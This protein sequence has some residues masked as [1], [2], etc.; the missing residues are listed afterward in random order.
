VTI[1]KAFAADMAPLEV[2]PQD[3]SRVFLNV[4]NNACYAVNEKSKKLNGSGYAPTLRVATAD[5]GEQVEVR[6]R[7]NGLGIPPEVREQIFNPFFTTKPTGQGT[8]LG[9]SISHDIVVQ[10]HGGQLEVQTEAGEF[11]EFVVRLPKSWRRAA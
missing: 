8:G 7:D 6:I 11:T 10:E 5:L 4:L 1:E 2:V 9:L 3:L